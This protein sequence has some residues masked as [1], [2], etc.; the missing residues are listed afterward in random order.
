MVLF[1]LVKIVLTFESV[2][3]ILWSSW[4][5]CTAFAF[6]ERRKPKSLDKNLLRKGENQQQ[7]QHTYGVDAR[8]PT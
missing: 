4:R 8:I 6:K 7:T 3:E 1:I 2:D 5:L